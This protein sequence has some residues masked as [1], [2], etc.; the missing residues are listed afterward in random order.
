MKIEILPGSTFPIKVMMAGHDVFAAMS[1]ELKAALL[2]AALN[3]L[4]DD[5]GEVA[6]IAKEH[7]WGG[8]LW[9]FTY[10]AHRRDDI[11]GTVLS[12]F[13]REIVDYL[14]VDSNVTA[15][16]ISA[17]V[18]CQVLTRAFL[19]K[20]V[21]V[22]DRRAARFLARRRLRRVLDPI[23][24]FA[25]PYVRLVSPAL[26]PGRPRL[27]LG[28]NVLIGRVKTRAAPRGAPV[29]ALDAANLMRV[30][31]SLATARL[32]EEG[33]ARMFGILS[34]SM[35]RFRESL[36][37]AGSVRGLVKKILS[38]SDIDSMFADLLREQSFAQTLFMC[39]RWSQ[40]CRFFQILQPRKVIVSS[41]F[42][43][44]ANR[45]PLAV[46]KSL[47]IPCELLACRPFLTGL[48]SEDRAIKADILQYNGAA[49]GDTVVVE[50][51]ESLLHLKR[52]GVTEES[53]EIRS[54][55]DNCGHSTKLI[56]D[57]ILLLFT[58]KK[59]NDGII[60]VL[61][62]VK[63]RG[64]DVRPIYV[65]EHPCIPVTERQKNELDTLGVS[66]QF[67]TMDPWSTLRFV[68]TVVLV[69]ESTSGVEAA[70][71]GADVLWCTFLSEQL[72]QLWPLMRATGEIME[73][74]SRAV[75]KVEKCFDD[76][77]EPRCVGATPDAIDQD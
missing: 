12:Y 14:M 20:G 4:D 30:D 27:P 41:M 48:R 38:Q 46:A 55:R 17:D 33:V 13:I 18:P 61:H 7:R 73:S 28:P 35:P 65:R 19:K 53:I 49:T 51:S 74:K 60:E 9:C 45:L 21:S 50:D 29:S 32:T 26:R 57:A 70:R 67:I 39:L 71:Q 16:T 40:Y 42:G 76:E 54:A 8:F 31:H 22:F 58:E 25:L 6:E 1:L 34:M 77:K 62:E 43:D 59:V 10:D 23:W 3:R 56:S 52:F 24:R 68:R 66:V 63:R 36:R 15:I 64:C 69:G 2:E 37:I 44:P 5:V 72:I 11:N 47:N 75:Q